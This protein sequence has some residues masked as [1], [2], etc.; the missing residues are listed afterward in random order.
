MIGLDAIPLYIVLLLHHS[1]SLVHVFHRLTW[2]CHGEEGECGFMLRWLALDGEPC[3]MRGRR[4]RLFGGTISDGVSRMWRCER[5]NALCV[6]A[7]RSFYHDAAF[8]SS[9]YCTDCGDAGKY[10]HMDR[11]SSTCLT[12]AGTASA[13]AAEGG[14]RGQAKRQHAEQDAGVVMC[15]H[16]LNVVSIRCRGRRVRGSEVGLLGVASASAPARVIIRFGG[17]FILETWPQLRSQAC[18]SVSR[19]ARALRAG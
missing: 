16:D 15:I 4:V 17:R 19:G 13:C 18:S 11:G 1:N 3:P 14:A 9:S 8:L 7:E 10:I 5:Y 6:V 2:S 12:R